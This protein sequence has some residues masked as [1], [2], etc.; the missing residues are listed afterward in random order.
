MG[1]VHKSIA[2]S[3]N[4]KDYIRILPFGVE[5]NRVEIKFSFFDES[6]I[7]RR[8]TLNKDE[9]ILL[10]KPTD[11]GFASHELSYHNS[12]TLHPNATILP[13][14][15]DKT[16]RKPILQEI[17]DLDLKNLLVPIPIC[18]ITVN[19]ES[20]LVYNPKNYHNNIDLSTKYNTTEIFISSAKY[21]FKSLSKRFP[22]IVE[23]LFPMTT[24]DFIVYGA[25]VGSE[26]I[27]NKMLE[28]KEP[29]TALESD[30]IGNYRFYYRTYELVKTNAFFLYSNREYSQNNFIEFFNNLDYL[31]LLATTNIGFKIQGTDRYDVK[32]A[33]KRDIE[34]LKRIGYHKDYIKR[35][36]NR[37]YKKEIEYNSLKKF[38]SGIILE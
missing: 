22:F 26:P 36:F 35:W 11:F 6:F 19:Q 4:G 33:Y 18:R 8:F 32:P 25:G 29:I 16:E 7:V 28:N 5:E 17:I 9:D 1:T 30:L 38:R 24:I 13:K 27:T 2:I 31:D 15:K 14:Y 21:D 34:N 3:K 12:N 10:Y 20:D 23:Y 37:F